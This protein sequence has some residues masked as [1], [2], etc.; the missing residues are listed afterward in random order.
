MGMVVFRSDCFKRAMRK[1]DILQGGNAR[2]IWRMGCV[3]CLGLEVVRMGWLRGG[4]GIG[5]T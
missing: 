1:E 2:G 5:E 3:R 4:M